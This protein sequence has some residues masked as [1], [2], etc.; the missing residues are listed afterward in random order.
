MM[1]PKFPRRIRPGGI[2]TNSRKHLLLGSSITY[3]M[4]LKIKAWDRYELVD[5]CIS[6]RHWACMSSLTTVDQYLQDVRDPSFC[7]GVITSDTA[8]SD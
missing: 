6:S 5:H 8:D 3:P 4:C 2:I 1:I 7:L